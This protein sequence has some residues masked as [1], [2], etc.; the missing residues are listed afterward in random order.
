MKKKKNRKRKKEKEKDG[1][2]RGLY[3]CF[4]NVFISWNFLILAGWARR[5][6]RGLKE[7][8]LSFYVGVIP[9]CFLYKTSSSNPI[10]RS[11]PLQNVFDLTRSLPGK[12]WEESELDLRNIVSLFLPLRT[13]LWRYL[14]LP[15]QEV[16]MFYMKNLC[17]ITVHK[18][19]CIIMSTVS[20]ANS[21]K[22]LLMQLDVW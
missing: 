3:L 16:R 15:K 20:L 13:L 2:E 5:G 9:V 1:R 22:G 17:E 7:L 14:S 12:D 11:A 10:L 18:V 21:V 19:I 6:L 4:L 8:F